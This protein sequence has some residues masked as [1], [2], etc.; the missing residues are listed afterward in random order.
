MDSVKKMI[1][2]DRVMDQTLTRAAHAKHKS[3]SQMIREAI[4]KY[5]NQA[6]FADLAKLDAR[7]AEYLGKP[8]SAVPFRDIMDE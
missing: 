7:M 4:A 8:A 6:E 3:V 1:Y 2:I 5:L